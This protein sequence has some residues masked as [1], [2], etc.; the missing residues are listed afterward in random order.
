[1]RRSLELDT[2]YHIYN[3]GYNKQTLF[4]VERD[5]GRFYDN[6]D[7][8]KLLFPNI[9]IVCFCILPNHFHFLLKEKNPGSNDPGFSSISPFMNRIQQSYAAFFNAKYGE[10]IKQGLKMPV[11]EGRF[12]AKEVTDEAYLSQLVN[13]IYYNP[14]KHGLVDN[15]EHWPYTFKSTTRVLEPGLG[16]EFDPYFE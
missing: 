4:F 9:E 3:R 6:L 10:S 12:Q 1:M 7:K 11:F 5:Y 16:E 14:V 8:Y 2:Y 13:Y 15:A